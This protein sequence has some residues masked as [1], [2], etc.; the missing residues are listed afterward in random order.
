VVSPIRDFIVGNVPG[1]TGDDTT[2]SAADGVRDEHVNAVTTRSQA[3]ARVGQWAPK[4]LKVLVL[5]DL[6]VSVAD[7]MRMQ[8][9][10]PDLAR[11]FEQAKTGKVV[12]FG[13]GAT[14]SVMCFIGFISCHQELRRIS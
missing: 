13:Q 9:Q 8:K 6:H 2:E 14:V 3:K 5:S 10:S 1:A 12:P 11:S 7:M 4:P